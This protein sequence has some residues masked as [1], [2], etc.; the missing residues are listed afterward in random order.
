M[1]ELFIFEFMFV[2]YFKKVLI[3]ILNKLNIVFKD[4]ILIL[5]LVYLVI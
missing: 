4:W 5:I 3:K 2:L 1:W